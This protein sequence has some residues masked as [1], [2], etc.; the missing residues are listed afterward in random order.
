MRIALYIIGAV[1]VLFLAYYLFGLL[2][3]GLMLVWQVLLIAVAV[4]ITAA[5][6]G[7]V[8]RVRRPQPLGAIKPIAA[9]PVKVQVKAEK[10]AE[11]NAEREL[12]TLEAALGKETT[13]VTRPTT[14][15][16]TVQQTRRR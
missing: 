10:K 12:R 15:E 11:R 4:A 3:A 14:D 9:Q 16:T 6:V 7:G 5:V 1:V 13:L 2:S 8:R